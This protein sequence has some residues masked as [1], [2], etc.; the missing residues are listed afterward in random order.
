MLGTVIREFEDRDAHGAAELL[1]GLHPMRLFSAERL[2][3]GNHSRPERARRRVWVADE[4]GEIVGWAHAQLNWA[5]GA[6]DVGWLW[7]GVRCDRRRRGV[8]SELWT[9]A[10]AHLRAHGAREFHSYVDNDAEG[11]RFVVR[12]GF[13]YA[14]E[15][16]YSAL[17][18]QQADTSSL[19]ELERTLR[20]QGLQAVPL[21][22]VLDRPRELHALYAAVLGDVPADHAATSL[23]YEDFVRRTLEDPGLDPDGSYVVV[24]GDRPVALAWLLVDGKSRRAENQMTGTL[25]A[26]RRRGL[27][28]LAKLAAIRWCAEHGIE[29]LVTSNDSTNVPMLALNRELGYRPVFSWT[30]YVRRD[31]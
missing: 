19:G 12:R 16:S 1:R 14:R 13:A 23:P 9:L 25:P 2:L 10:E 4:D 24:D 26:Y 21:G 28:R 3:H 27:A 7:V 18:P 11:E 6:D 22:S 5:G 29:R 31:E 20:V 30:F 8:G 15:D 17:D